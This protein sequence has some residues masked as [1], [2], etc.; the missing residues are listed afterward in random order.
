MDVCGEWDG[1]ACFNEY[2]DDG[3]NG[4]VEVSGC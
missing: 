3:D 4:V 2:G 1:E